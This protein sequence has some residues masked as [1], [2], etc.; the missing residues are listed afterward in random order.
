MPLKNLVYF[1][2]LLY[3]PVLNML[4]NKCVLHVYD[5]IWLLYFS[6]QLTD[7]YSFHVIILPFDSGQRYVACAE[8]SAL[9]WDEDVLRIKVA[10]LVDS[11]TF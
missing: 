11:F 3:H 10:G 6:V 1:A 8:V 5:N 4:S 7:N 2:H 9:L